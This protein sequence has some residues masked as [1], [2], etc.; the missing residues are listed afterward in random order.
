[1]KTVKG[2]L[3]HAKFSGQDPYLALL[4]YWSTSIDAHLCSP[5]TMLYQQALCTTLPQWIRHT[6]PHANAECDNFNQ[7]A[8]QNTEC[9][10][11]QG[12]CKKPPFF[13]SQ[14]ISAINDVRNLWLP[15]PSSTKPIMAYTWSESL[16]VDSTEMVMTTLRKSPGCCQTRYIQHWQCSTSCIH[17]SSWHPGSETAISCCTHNTNVSCTSSYTAN[18]MQSSTC[19][20]FA[21]MNTYAIHW[22][23]SNPD[24]HRPCCPTPINSKQEATIQAS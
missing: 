18:S 8:T 4:A 23:S 22:I 9:H 2:L 19:S 11:Q 13:A 10:D 15:P 24:W 3:T 12:C 6:D 20:T 21:T 14:T 1:M 16:V 5:A 17:I 7:H